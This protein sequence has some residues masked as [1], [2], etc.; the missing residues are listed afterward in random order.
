MIDVIIATNNKDKLCE[1]SGLLK[2]YGINCLSLG[3]IGFADEIEEDGDTFFDNAYKKASFISK[4]Y[5]LP[6]LGDDS[7][8]VVD[9][10]PNE[11]GV[12]SKRFSP[13]AIDKENNDLLLIKLE[14]EINRQ[15]HFISQIVLYFPGGRFFAYQGRIDGEIARDFRGNNG[16]G[17]DPLFIINENGKRMAELTRDEKNMISHRG[18]ALAKLIE[19]IDNEIVTFQ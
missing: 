2:P 8:L 17:Y 16:F 11:L 3:D 9:S 10:L 19:D 12:R 6:A 7:G 14:H 4:K 15:A 5:N 18:R 13:S 1:I